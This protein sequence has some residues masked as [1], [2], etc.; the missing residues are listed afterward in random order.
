[1]SFLFYLD[2]EILLDLSL[3]IRVLFDLILFC[4]YRVVPYSV[5]STSIST[6]TERQWRH[7]RL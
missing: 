3:N 4:V 5:A 1:M 2:A 6:T 7:R